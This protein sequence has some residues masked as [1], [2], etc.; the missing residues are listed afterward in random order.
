MSE[1]GDVMLK[2]CC[3]GI[4]LFALFFLA[5]CAYQGVNE[6]PLATAYPA[7]QDLVPKM[8]E[9]AARH[10][11]LL[12]HRIIGFTETENLPIH[13][14]ELGKG[15]RNILII[16]QHHGDEILGV[17]LAFQLFESL[18]ER[19]HKEPQVQGLLDEFKL[20]IVPSLNPEGWRV[21]SANLTR[22]KRKNNR[23]T[24]GNGK[25]DLR[26]DGVDLNRNYPVFWDLDTEIDHLSP[27]YKGPQPASEKEIQAIIALGRKVSFD[28]AIFYHSSRTGTLNETIFLPAVDEP[29]EDFLAL[30][31]LAEFY[32]QN[33]PRDYRPG[34]YSLHK[35]VS[36]K[37]GNARNSF[38]H[39]LDVPAIL[40]EIGGV[41][42]EGKS[43]IHPSN[44]MV[45]RIVS[46][47]EKALLKVMERMREI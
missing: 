46:R 23:D 29:R 21:V 18:S 6:Y 12:M 24:D 9:L 30:Q 8:N 26:T 47:H 45:K 27:F 17:A 40:I 15:Q 19:Y 32:A 28:L 13:A 25:L 5:S 37:V 31:D 36:S 16:G 33:V 1:F 42:R 35:N 3:S 41:N 2:L 38:Y 20:W 10:P 44:K 14:I 7:P 22:T 39:S 43:I 34:T 4:P 11:G